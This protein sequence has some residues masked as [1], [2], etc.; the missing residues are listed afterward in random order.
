MPVINQSNSSKIAD[1][2]SCLQT[3]NTSLLT[4]GP[5]QVLRDAPTAYTE[6]EVIPDVGSVANRGVLNEETLGANLGQ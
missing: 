5:P 3:S 1:Y 4:L 2:A 6:S